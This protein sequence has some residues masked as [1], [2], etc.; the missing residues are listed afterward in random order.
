LNNNNLPPHNLEFEKAVLSSLINNSTNVTIDEVSMLLT[1]E[2]FYTHSNKIIYNAILELNKKNIA[3]DLLTLSKILEDK[4]QIDEV[5]GRIGV[6]EISNNFTNV[7]QLQHKCFYLKEL[8]IRRNLI[9]EAHNILSKVYSLDEDIFELM[10]EFDNNISKIKNIDGTSTNLKHIR[11]SVDSA[12]KQLDQAMNEPI[13]VEGIETGFTNID[14]ILQGMKNGQ[15]IT[16]AARPAMAKTSLLTNI[17]T[18]VAKKSNKAVLF[19]S[20]EMTNRELMLR[21]MSAESELLSHKIAQGN[22]TSQDSIRVVEGLNKYY[23]TNL[24]IDDTADITPNKMR[25]IAKKVK[26]DFGSIALIGIDFVQI[27]KSKDKVQNRDTEIS[28]ITRDIKILAKEMDCPIIT[29]SQLSRECEKRADKRPMLSDLRDSGTI[30]QNSDV[31]MFIHRPEY[32]GIQ[33]F[34]DGESAI[35][36]AEIIVA[37][38]RGGSVGTI[39]LGFEGKYT[40]FKNLGYQMP[41]FDINPNRNIEPNRDDDQF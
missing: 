29:L 9:K 38:N 41:S 30:E 37:K 10:D 25:A 31:V 3:V 19:F 33:T 34:E 8:T 35:D 16:I 17:L 12:I 13:K 27:I 14:G 2:D 11:E 24:L 21:I 28:N 6:T 4:N 32:Y 40:R 20:L 36:M 39:R 22:I 5:G 1:D 26:R 18:N 23:D 7:S 15:S